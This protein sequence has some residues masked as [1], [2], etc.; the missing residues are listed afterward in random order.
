MSE[1]LTK[2]K[3]LKKEFNALRKMTAAPKVKRVKPPEKRRCGR[4]KD[5]RVVIQQKRIDSLPEI[6]GICEISR[7]LNIRHATLQQW[8]ALP[9]HPLPFVDREGRRLF[10]K[11]LLVKWLIATKRYKLKPEYLA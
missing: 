10:R 6:G 9:V 2:D 5:G 1:D 3:E 4:P 8:C 11:D 7:T